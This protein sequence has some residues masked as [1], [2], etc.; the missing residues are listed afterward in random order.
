MWQ[1]T[2]VLSYESTTH[3]LCTYSMAYCNALYVYVYTYVY[4][5]Y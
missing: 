5:V 1:C 3:T 4:V 2:F